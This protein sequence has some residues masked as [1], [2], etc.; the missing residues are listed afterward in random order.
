MPRDLAKVWKIPRAF[1]RNCHPDGISLLNA[2][3]P[4]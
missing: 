2:A 4:L 1:V 3:T